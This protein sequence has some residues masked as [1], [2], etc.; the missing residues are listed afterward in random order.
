MKGNIACIH[1]RLEQLPAADD[2][3]AAAAV[4]AYFYSS[5]YCLSGGTNTRHG[6]LF[7]CTNGYAVASCLLYFY[8]NLFL[9]FV[10]ILLFLLIFLLF[11]L[12]F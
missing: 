5:S 2:A 9:F 3:A 1:G 10:T 6:S 4:A 8:Y 12:G 11:A 7:L